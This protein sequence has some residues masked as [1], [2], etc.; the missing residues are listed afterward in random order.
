MNYRVHYVTLPAQDIFGMVGRCGGGYNTI[1][2][3]WSPE[4]RLKRNIIMREYERGLNAISGH[5]S[6]LEESILKEGMRNPVIIT[7]GLPRKRPME[8]LP[9]ELRAVS[10]ERL[11]LLESSMGGS[12]LHVCQK[13]NMEIACIVND[14]TGRFKDEPEIKNEEDARMCFMDQPNKIVFDPE[15]GLT[16][17]F[18]RDKIGYHL[19]PEWSEDKIMPLRAPLWI[20]LMNKY[21]YKIDKLPKIV[22]KVLEDAGIDQSQVG[23]ANAQT[24]SIGSYLAKAEQDHAGED[25]HAG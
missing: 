11:L 15:L 17:S 5:Y 4:G 20:G 13:H 6:K 21:G 24:W 1:W 25:T 2:V 23:T 16:E 7:C 19:G 22:L 12:R 9:P 14:W 3:D 18:D 8:C 10:P